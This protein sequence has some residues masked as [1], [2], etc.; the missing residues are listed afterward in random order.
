MV[1]SSK[2]CIPSSNFKINGC[3]LD[4]VLKYKH[5]GL[6]F[7]NNGQV[8]SAQEHLTDRA[9]KAWFAIRN[10]L[11]N[12]KAWPVNVYLKSF[13]SVIKP[14]L[15]YGSEI[16]GQYMI[17]RKDSTVFKMPKFDVSL[18]CKSMQAN[19]KGSQKSH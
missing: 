4:F 3:E 19:I 18:P 14:I 13:E 12:I 6:L 1:A 7:S 5:L 9:T 2:K 11:F 8:Q 17:N 10:G 15:M 16:W